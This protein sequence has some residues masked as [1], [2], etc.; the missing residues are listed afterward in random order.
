MPANDPQNFQDKEQQ[1][2]ALF[3][4]ERALV[5]AMPSKLEDIYRW[6]DLAEQLNNPGDYRPKHH[7]NPEIEEHNGFLKY[8]PA[9]GLEA[10]QRAPK[11]TWR[12]WIFWGPYMGTKKKTIYIKKVDTTLAKKDG[13]NIYF[14]GGM[15]STG[16]IFD[17][18]LVDQPHLQEHKY[19]F[20]GG[21]LFNYGQNTWEGGLLNTNSRPWVMPKEGIRH[22]Y[23]GEWDY[24]RWKDS[25]YNFSPVRSATISDVRD[26]NRR[27]GKSIWNPIWNI[28][29]V[30]VCP[31]KA[32]VTAI[33]CMQSGKLGTDQHRH[34]L[35]N[36]IN[37]IHKKYWV[38]RNLSDANGIKDV[39]I[40]LLPSKEKM[41]GP[42]NLNQELRIYDAMEQYIDIAEVLYP[43]DQEDYLRIH[44]IEPT[45]RLIEQI[46][47]ADIRKNALD[48]LLRQIKDDN[49]DKGKIKI[50]D[51]L[52]AAVRACDVDLVKNIFI[53]LNKI[54]GDGLYL[55]YI[56]EGLLSAAKYEKFSIFSNLLD[57]AASWKNYSNQPMNSSDFETIIADS[58]K[59][60]YLQKLLDKMGDRR[61]IVLGSS[62]SIRN[63]TVN[64][65]FSKLSDCIYPS[66]EWQERYA[67][68]KSTIK[69][70]IKQD[71]TLKSLINQ[72]KV[73]IN[74]QRLSLLEYA[75][76]ENDYTFAYWL[77]H[78][79]LGLSKALL[80]KEI[81]RGSQYV[82]PL[83]MQAGELKD[84]ACQ[85]IL[86]QLLEINDTDSAKLLLKNNKQFRAD[87][88]T[89]N[90]GNG[91]KELLDYALHTAK[92][93]QLTQ[94]LIQHGCEKETLLEKAISANFTQLVQDL[95]N[96]QCQ[97]Y[98]DQ[99][100]L[101]SFLTHLN[102]KLN[103][104]KF[105]NTN[106]TGLSNIIAALAPASTTDP[107]K[108][109][110]NIRNIAA[111]RLMGN[112]IERMYRHS[113]FFGNGRHQN[114]EQLY[115]MLACLDIINQENQENI[116]SFIDENEFVYE[117][118]NSSVSHVCRRL[119]SFSA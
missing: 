55:W 24:N 112:R 23:K 17:S 108:C 53:I 57:E 52:H 51:F 68:L 80:Q 83:L 99:I 60:L 71:G 6:D 61:L 94:L 15:Y 44:H 37:S 18:D 115:Q 49:D 114:V 2:L 34:F 13:K 95:I 103:D 75:I 63:A 67:Q 29:T 106:N 3:E 117:T 46:D 74:N 10:Q 92:D 88:I 118:S 32:S 59:T 28:N 77:I 79:Q 102:N 50:R 31:S 101:L 69:A 78:H 5:K 4:S 16:I 27:C 73:E 19:I 48:V 38:K 65:L 93:E 116:L 12:K 43:I 107:F 64:K 14:D 104:K 47:R 111:Q 72:K 84:E 98:T 42:T 97:Q 76:K 105:K 30:M 54:C 8:N 56:D 26:H 113:H 36:K 45:K 70:V 85:A 91:H 40:V 119:Q 96:Q 20:T 110:A 81:Q 35:I 25:S 62:T 66:A 82:R 90:L 11:S 109:A 41:N 39:P 22:S 9:E 58:P 33:S 7:F 100:G 1:V 21:S 89:L 87:G 86:K